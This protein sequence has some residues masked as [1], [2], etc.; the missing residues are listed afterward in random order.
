MSKH[1]IFL[2]VPCPGEIQRL[3]AAYQKRWHFLP[4]RWIP[5]QNLHLTVLPPVYLTDD[6][7]A[8]MITSLKKE[9]GQIPAFEILFERF[10]LAPPGKPARMIWLAGKPQLALNRLREAAKAVFPAGDENRPLIPHITIARMQPADWKRYLPK[11]NI[12]EV[13]E[14]KMPVEKIALME[15]ILKR[16]GAEYSILELIPLLKS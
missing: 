2:G 15:S 9:I 5:L 12:E 4:V 1:R 6:E 3:I 14:I 8:K 7:I 13:L 10:L 11:P 16:G